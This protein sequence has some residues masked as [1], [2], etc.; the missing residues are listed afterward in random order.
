MS[1][2]TV[3]EAMSNRLITLKDEASLL[4]VYK[5]FEQSRI[6]G[7]PVMSNNGKYVG[8]LSK[9]DLV[10]EKLAA[11]VETGAKLDGIMVKE[12]MNP[13][14]PISVEASDSLDS[15][16]EIMLQKKIHRLFVRNAADKLVG[17]VTT[18]DAVRLLKEALDAQ[19]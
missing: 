6:S 14:L 3:A 1:K 18:L 16:V 7:A 13:N 8:V 5:I 19:S 10:S 12:M 9:T 2:T 17:V 11:V 15:A 4:D